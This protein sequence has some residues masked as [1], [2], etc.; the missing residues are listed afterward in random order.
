MIAD[1]ILE[2]LGED[3]DIIPIDSVLEEFQNEILH[4]VTRQVFEKRVSRPTLRLSSLG[5]CIKQQAFNVLDYPKKPL[6][7]RAKMTFLF[8]DV[9]EAIVVALAKSSGVNLHSEQKEVDFYGVKG[10][11]DGII[12]DDTLFECKSM[13]PFGY[14]RFIRN[15]IDNQGGYISQCQAYMHGLGL[16]QACLVVVNKAT[17]HIAEQIIKPNQS[18]IDNLISNIDTISSLREGNITLD[19]LPRID[20][21]EETYYKK[22]T[23]NLKL[24]WRCSY[25]DYIDYCWKDEIV[26]AFKNGKPIYYVAS[27]LNK[28][29]LP[30][31]TK[32][33]DTYG[34]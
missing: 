8:G 32:I 27:S 19:Q 10:H 11:I 20:T 21:I 5:K 23:G 4:G 28:D 33:T 22:K 14:D 24:D 1:K 18:Y 2:L 6:N 13:S 30:K 25:C 9:V 29:T 15:G 16:K 3:K 17:G 26:L 31:G 12:D 34:D 7:A